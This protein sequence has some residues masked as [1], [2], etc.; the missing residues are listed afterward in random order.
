MESVSL[1]PSLGA[2]LSHLS[3]EAPDCSQEGTFSFLL[4]PVICARYGSCMHETVGFAHV[5]DVTA[6]VI[7]MVTGRA[8]F[9]H[10]KKDMTC[11]VSKVI[12]A[13]M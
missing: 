11:G 10:L 3:K 8:S 1:W 2:G 4:T 6:L 12:W 5:D 9:R 7:P 13:S